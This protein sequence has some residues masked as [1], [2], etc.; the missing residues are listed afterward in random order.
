MR[1]LALAPV[2]VR[3]EFQR[4]GLGSAMITRALVIA[5]DRQIDAVFVVGDPAYYTRVGF[6]LEAAAGYSGVYAGP[7]FMAV[8]CRDGLADVGNISLPKAF[9]EFD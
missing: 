7:Y 2:G 6:S 1:A 3:P 9:N 5:R 8:G 4:H